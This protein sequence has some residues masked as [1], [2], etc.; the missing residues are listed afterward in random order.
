LPKADVLSLRALNRATL[1]RQLLL[2]RAHLPALDAVEHL[3]GMQAQVPLDPYTGLWSRLE[4]FRPEE[5]AQLLLDRKA[6]RIV[7][8]R[9]T[10]HLVSADDCLLLRPLMQPVLDREIARHPQFGPALLEVDLDPV[11]AFARTLVAERARTGAELR[12]AMQ[13]RFPTQDGGAL[14]YAC[15]CLLAF[16]QVPPRGVWGRT[17]QVTST[18]AESW[19]GRPLAT[20]P[21]I[22]DVVLRYLAAFGP[23]TVADAATWSRLTGLRAVVDRLRPRLRTFRDERG[24]ELVDLPDAPRPDPET[25]APPRFL[26]EYDNVLLSHADRSRFVSKEQRARLSRVGGPVRGSVLHD[27]FLCG[28]WRI[29]RDPSTGAATLVVAHLEA[30]TKRAT[31]RLAAEGRRL[32]RFLAPDADARDVRFE[33]VGR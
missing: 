1:E 32:L 30:L 25:P 15:R 20:D 26:P 13:E 22:D 28:T 2:R 27:G 23:A 24:R 8:M 12:A 5:L 17:A 11:L 21:S 18:T 16:V 31:A 10:I 14:A 19:L 4:G 29:D 6:V 3:V 9:A 7:V 33:P